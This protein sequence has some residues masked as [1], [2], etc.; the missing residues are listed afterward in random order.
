MESKTTNE[1]ARDKTQKRRARD[2]E[3]RSKPE[4]SHKEKRVRHEEADIPNKTAASSNESANIGRGQ[5]RH[6]E[7]TDRTETDSKDGYVSQLNTAVTDAAR[8]AS[9]LEEDLQL[10]SVNA[11]FPNKIMALLDSGE[12]PQAM[13]W[14]PQGDSFCIVQANFDPVLKKHFQ[15]TKFES[16]TRKLNRWYVHLLIAS[17]S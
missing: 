16:F 5:F 13:W 7:S 10:E 15:G 9:L 2:A 12:E 14:Q 3:S 6:S 1:T 4:D 8:V 11:F 17:P